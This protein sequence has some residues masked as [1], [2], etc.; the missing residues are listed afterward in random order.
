MA[1]LFVM[2]MNNCII[3]LPVPAYFFFPPERFPFLGFLSVSEV[4]GSVTSGGNIGP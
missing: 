2:V 3:K 4:S 1:L